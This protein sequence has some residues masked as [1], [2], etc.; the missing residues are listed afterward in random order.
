T[1]PN[2]PPIEG[3]LLRAFPD[4]LPSDELNTKIDESFVPL[5][6][7]TLPR[8]PEEFRSWRE[9]KLTELLRIA[10]RPIFH[11]TVLADLV[12]GSVDSQYAPMF[13]KLPSGRTSPYFPGEFPLKHSGLQ[14]E[15]GIV[16]FG[17]MGFAWKYFPG[18]KASA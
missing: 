3:K 1:E 4:E 18:A 2:L 7:N 14:V 13:R 8:N 10:F 11:E 5:A 6:T 15:S 12:H 16:D 9:E 17:S